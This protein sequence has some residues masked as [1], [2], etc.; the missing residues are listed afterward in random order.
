MN[1]HKFST[2]NQFPKL[3]LREWNSGFSDHEYHKK[4]AEKISSMWIDVLQHAQKKE[5]VSFSYMKD[6]ENI[7]YEKIPVVMD[8]T[9]EKEVEF[10]IELGVYVDPI[11]T[12]KDKTVLS[13]GVFF[14]DNKTFVKLEVNN[15]KTPTEVLDEKNSIRRFASHE[16]THIIKKLYNN[17]QK[18]M[19][20]FFKGGKLDYKSYLTNKH[21]LDA[22]ISEINS[23]LKDIHGKYANLSFKDAMNLSEVYSMYKKRLYS[24]ETKIFNKIISKCLNYWTEKIGGK[25]K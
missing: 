25:V 19:E 9:E 1:R 13:A 11:K 23:E 2:K 21:E 18:E 4:L 22:Y 15:H 7:V 24:Y 20:T 12:N 17:N 6:F 8:I 10:F 14:E 3:Y 5:Y 16:T